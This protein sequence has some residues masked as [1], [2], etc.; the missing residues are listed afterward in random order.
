MSITTEQVDVLARDVARQWEEGYRLWEEGR[1][2][3]PSP[4]DLYLVVHHTLSI[5]LPDG[6]EDYIDELEQNGEGLDCL[7]VA[8]RVVQRCYN[9]RTCIDCGEWFV[10]LHTKQR[11]CRY[12]QA[13]DEL[14]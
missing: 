9:E 5:P 6:I 7:E 8:R 12:C 14:G 10:P 11:R 2:P 3:S 1:L 13:A 4:H